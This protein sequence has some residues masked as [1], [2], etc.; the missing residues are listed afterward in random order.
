M[1]CEQRV[2]W[3]CDNAL[4]KGFDDVMCAYGAEMYFGAAAKYVVAI[5]L[6][7]MNAM[8]VQPALVMDGSAASL[9]DGG[10]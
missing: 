3:D 9:G 4:L 7:N 8:V 6:A 5:L 10:G 2:L 1:E